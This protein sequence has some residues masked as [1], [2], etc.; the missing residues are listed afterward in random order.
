MRARRTIPAVAGLAFVVA[1]GLA[2]AGVAMRVGQVF[3]DAGEPL[4]MSG[5]GQAKLAWVDGAWWGVFSSA[6]GVDLFRLQGST[7]VQESGGHSHLSDDPAAR[8][9]VLTDGSELLV[10]LNETVGGVPALRLYDFAYVRPG[11]RLRGGYPVVVVQRSA[12]DP[13]QDDMHTLVLDSHRRL[14]VAYRAGTACGVKGSRGTGPSG[15][16]TFFPAVTFGNLENG[17]AENLSNCVAVAT[18][19]GPDAKVGVLWADQSA[20]PQNAYRFR[21]RLDSSPS[22]ALSAWSPEEVAYTNGNELVANDQLMA[23]G[24]EGKV[25]AAVKTDTTPSAANVGQDRFA[26]LVRDASGS[27]SKTTIDTIQSSGDPATR[28]QIALDEEHRRIYAFWHRVGIVGKATSVDAPSFLGASPFTVLAPVSQTSWDSQTTHQLL[29]SRTGFLVVADDNDTGFQYWSYA[30]LG[31]PA[32]DVTTGPVLATVSLAP[33]IAT[34]GT[35]SSVQLTASA[36]DQ[37]GSAFPIT[38][39]WTADGGSIDQTGL[40]TSGTTTGVFGVAATQSETA[41]GTVFVGPSP[42]ITSL[43]VSPDPATL[44]Q[45][46]SVQLSAAGQTSSGDTV[47]LVGSLAWSLA[48]GVGSVDANGLY[49]APPTQGLATVE[50][51]LGNLRG[52]ASVVV[53]PPGPT[54]GGSGGGGSGGGGSGGG[55]SGGSG[56]GPAPS[57][58]PAASPTPLRPVASPT[59]TAAPATSGSS[60]GGGGG[61]G[62]GCELAAG[63]RTGPTALA[64]LVVL[65]AVLTVRARAR[66]PRR[67]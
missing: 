14:W 50:V 13:L 63:A 23:V 51:Q 1:A 64:P 29:S 26:L 66:R 6:T 28:P 38:P 18:G 4:S 62:G 9:D 65:A 53:L 3:R 12:T 19:S 42:L 45:G 52:F 46:G 8:A 55:G 27:W 32:Q 22:F 25:L 48:S 17:V 40:Y 16:L 7:W 35:G 67:S 31:R 59:P 24:F 47:A 5:K 11:M 20:P 49:Q 15:W 57:P 60:S 44:L 43:V 36:Q 21:Y 41:H 54:G 10:L 2:H 61:G 33:S 30:S 39:T 37:G 58:V 34:V 56:R